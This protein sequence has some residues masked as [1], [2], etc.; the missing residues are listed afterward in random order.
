MFCCVQA[1][2]THTKS[3]GT[4]STDDVICVIGRRWKDPKLHRNNPKFSLELLVLTFP[5]R[6]NIQWETYQWNQQRYAS[7]WG[8]TI[9]NSVTANEHKSCKSMFKLRR[10]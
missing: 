2:F 7:K 8:V 3:M 4:H 1:D 5:F 10:Y 9:A 6:T